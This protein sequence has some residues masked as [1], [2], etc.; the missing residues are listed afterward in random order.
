MKTPMETENELLKQVVADLSVK[1]FE[2]TR[3][4]K[5]SQIMQEYYGK[6]LSEE[7]RKNDPRPQAVINRVAVTADENAISSLTNKIV[8]AAEEEPF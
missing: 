8:V 4:L 3:D 5:K 1:L 7:L 2:A 6:R